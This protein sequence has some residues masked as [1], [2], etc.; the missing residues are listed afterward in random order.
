M[1]RSSLTGS[2]QKLLFLCWAERNNGGRSGPAGRTVRPWLLGFG[3]N[4][5]GSVLRERNQ[6]R[7]V[8]PSNLGPDRNFV[9]SGHEQKWT[10]DGPHERRGRSAPLNQAC[11][12]TISSLS[13]LILWTADGLPL[14]RGQSAG[15]C[16]GRLWHVMIVFLAVG[17]DRRTVR[18]V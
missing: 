2:G 16:N 17:F 8:R 14:V 15:C 5:C 12:E 6:G 4:G 10:A 18:F 3:Q 9:V 13:R 1:V 11:P 7:T